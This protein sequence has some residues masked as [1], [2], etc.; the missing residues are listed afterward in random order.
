MDTSP[1]PEVQ[2]LLDE[3]RCKH[4]DPAL[5]GVTDCPTPPVTTFQ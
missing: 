3:E 1:T 2:K 5:Y 4:M